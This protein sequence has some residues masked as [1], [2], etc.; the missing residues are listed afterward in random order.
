MRFWPITNR[1]QSFIF[2][3]NSTFFVAPAAFLSSLHLVSL[4][5]FFQKFLGNVVSFVV[6]LYVL[7][8]FRHHIWT[9]FY[10]PLCKN[11]VSFLSKLETFFLFTYRGFSKHRFLRIQKRK[12]LH[13]L[14][15]RVNHSCCRLIQTQTSRKRFNHLNR[16]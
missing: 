14:N 3:F 8:I 11:G 16:G 9:R 6:F 12:L 13:R 7:V 5:S 2:R 10:F 15:P 4:Y 1:T